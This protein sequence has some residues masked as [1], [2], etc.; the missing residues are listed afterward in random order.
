MLESKQNEQIK[1]YKKLQTR[2]GRKKQQ[3][4]VIEGPHLVEAA[5]LAGAPIQHIYYVVDK[6]DVRYAP[7]PHTE[8]SV[9]L[10]D[11]LS[12]TEHSQ[13]V[14]AQIMLPAYQQLPVN[15]L[16][17]PVILLDGVQDPGNLGTIIRTADALG[18]KNIILGEGTVDV[19][20]DKVLRSMQGSHFHLNLYP[21]NLI[22][23][24]PELQAL[25]YQI[26]ASVL[27]ANAV[28]I[29]Q[30]IFSSNKWGIVLGNEG[31]GVSDV[32]QSLTDISLYIPMTGQAESFNVAIAAAIMMYAFA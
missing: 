20:N 12:E 23:V 10:A 11:Y 27:N 13:G 4:Y 2:R 9:T 17:T 5:I 3:A 24:I 22:Q 8:I 15:Q 26:G 18:Y 21:A 1:T 25:D 30:H 16:T 7:Y 31:N 6:Y 19:Y 32:V 28:S 14:Y 29:K